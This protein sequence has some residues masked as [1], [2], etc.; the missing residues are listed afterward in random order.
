MLNPFLVLNSDMKCT[1]F[2]AI[3]A[4]TMVAIPQPLSSSGFVA[5]TVPEDQHHMMMTNNN[6]MSMSM[7]M[8]RG[9]IA[10]GFNQNKIRHNFISS[11]SGGEI[12]ITAIDNNDTETIKQIRHHTM[13]IQK[14]FSQG[15]FTRPFFIHAQQVPGTKVMSEKKDLIKYNI[16]DMKN[17]SALVLDTTDKQLI[18][19]IGQFMMFQATAHSG[20]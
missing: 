9:N 14:E 10:M 19:A 17:G 13:D 1:P 15:N 5:M 7:M 11:P 16:L 6:T 20:H 12:I 18:H 8:E 3:A 2:L 4:L